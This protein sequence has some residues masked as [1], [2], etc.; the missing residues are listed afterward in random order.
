M[1][2]E[3]LTVQ[4]FLAAYGNDF[5]FHYTSAAAADSISEDM[6]FQTEAGAAHGYGFY[7]TDIEPADETTIEEV[8]QQCFH[9]GRIEAELS[10][11]LILFPRDAS[12]DFSQVQGTREWL[13]PTVGPL[14]LIQLDALLAAVARWDGAEWRVYL[15][16]L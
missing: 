4:A 9:G 6:V 2:E 12:H 5:L 10:S 13:V 11:V 16:Q 3:D 8:S 1:Y 14:E 7:A 15:T